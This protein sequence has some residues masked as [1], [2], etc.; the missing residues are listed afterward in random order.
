MVGLNDDWGG[1]REEVS[2]VSSLDLWR[3]CGHGSQKP[4]LSSFAGS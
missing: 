3:P 1:K 2:E 4:S